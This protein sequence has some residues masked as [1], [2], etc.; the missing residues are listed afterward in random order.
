M[1]GAVG[2]GLV[3]FDIRELETTVRIVVVNPMTGAVNA[4]P[5]LRLLT[6]SDPTMLQI[7]LDRNTYHYKVI[8]LWVS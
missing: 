5:D 2:A 6:F 8:L 7:I 1:T 4:L 3:C